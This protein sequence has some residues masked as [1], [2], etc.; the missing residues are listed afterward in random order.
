MRGVP[1]IFSTV[2]TSF[3]TFLR[4]LFMT[5]SWPLLST[6]GF[7]PKRMT[8]PKMLTARRESNCKRPLPRMRKRTEMGPFQPGPPVEDSTLNH[9]STISAQ[10]FPKT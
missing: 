2:A 3:S 9:L 1:A 8:E 7:A 5:T 6:A 10:M 4:S